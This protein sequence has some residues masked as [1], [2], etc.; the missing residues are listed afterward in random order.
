MKLTQHQLQQPIQLPNQPLLIPPT[1]S[2]LLDMH[3]PRPFNKA[4]VSVQK[5][6]QPGVYN[7]AGIEHAVRYNFRI[8]ESIS[9]AL[10]QRSKG[11]QVL[12]RREADI[13]ARG[14]IDLST[15]NQVHT[16]LMSQDWLSLL[17]EGVVGHNDNVWELRKRINVGVEW[18]KRYLKDD[19]VTQELKEAASKRLEMLFSMLETMSLPA[20]PEERVYGFHVDLIIPEFMTHIQYEKARKNKVFIRG[21]KDKVD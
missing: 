20:W 6:S 2:E 19:N 13:A 12:S 4:E 8:V 1:T 14:K 16:L 10:Y 5:V 3:Q 9:E 17:V 15:G 18:I 21:M 11:I 7:M